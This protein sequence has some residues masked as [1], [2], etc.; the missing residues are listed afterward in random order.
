MVACFSV[1]SGSGLLPHQCRTLWGFRSPA[2]GMRWIVPTPKPVASA[3]FL[4]LPGVRAIYRSRAGKGHHL[5]SL[6]LRYAFT[7]PASGSVYETVKANRLKSFAPFEAAIVAKACF[8]GDSLQR[9][10]FGCGQDNPCSD[11]KALSGFT[12]CFPQAQGCQVLRRQFKSLGWGSRLTP[13]GA[14]LYISI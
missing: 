1:N 13:P 7:T 12:R 2:F 6:L 4:T 3:S 8:L 5:Q 9:Q 14:T 10:S 11:G